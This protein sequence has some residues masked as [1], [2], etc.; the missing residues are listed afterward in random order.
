MRYT[1]VT[2]WYDDFNFTVHGNL[3]LLREVMEKGEDIA[4][5]ILAAELILSGEETVKLLN[6]F[7][8]GKDREKYKDID[9]GGT[10]SVRAYDW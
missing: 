3:G 5:E 7:C 9:L 8:A 2:G 4:G 10:Y 6:R 1:T